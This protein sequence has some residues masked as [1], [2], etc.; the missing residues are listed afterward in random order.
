M[1]P[2]TMVII[3]TAYPKIAGVGREEMQLGVSDFSINPV[4][5]D[6]AVFSVEKGFEKKNLEEEVEVIT[7]T[8][9]DWWRLKRVVFNPLCLSSRRPT[10]IRSKF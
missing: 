7:G 5:L 6:L 4:D 3:V 9:R 10:W 8:L 2:H 1:N